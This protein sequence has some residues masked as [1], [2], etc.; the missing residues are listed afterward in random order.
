M[1]AL[2]PPLGRCGLVTLDAHHDVRGFHAGP[3]NGTPV[4]GLIED[5]LPG[6]HV[7][8][9]GIAD[10]SNS[11]AYR[12]YCEQHGISLVSVRE[13]T[14][15]GVG[16]CVRRVAGR[17]GDVVRGDLRRPGRGRGRLGVRAGLSGARPGGLMPGDLLDAA[18]E[19]GRH[20]LVRAV[21]IVEVDADAGC[22]RRHGRPGGDVPAVRGGRLRRPRL[23]SITGCW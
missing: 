6:K 7:V 3:T 10:W 21:D 14:R 5:G 11:L 4:R 17:S 13:A 2:L 8:Q 15:E 9:I 23:T 1:R 18:R 20:P 22:L 19:A 16:A 12:G